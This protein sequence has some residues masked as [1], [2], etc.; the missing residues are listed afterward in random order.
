MRLLRVLE[1]KMAPYDTNTELDSQMSDSGQSVDG[2]QTA[3]PE[4][5]SKSATKRVEKLLRLLC[6][7]PSVGEHLRPHI[8]GLLALSG[9]RYPTNAIHV[10]EAASNVIILLSKECLSSSLVKFLFDRNMI[11]HMT[12]DAKELC[13]MTSVTSVNNSCLHGTQCWWSKRCCT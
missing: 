1:L 2:S 5:I 13:G 3:N 6:R 11:G 8:F 12:D 10:T 9:A 4:S 7:D